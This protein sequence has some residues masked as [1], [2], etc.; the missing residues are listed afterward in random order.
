MEAWK[1]TLFTL[2]D[3]GDACLHVDAAR[4]PVMPPRSVI[5]Q[6]LVDTQRSLSM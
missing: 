5:R 4:P 1:V 6:A 2:P 3:L